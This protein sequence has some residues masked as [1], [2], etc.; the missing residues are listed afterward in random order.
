MREKNNCGRRVSLIGF[1][2]FEREDGDG[3][4]KVCVN[5]WL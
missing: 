3:G 1:S 5:G 2:S 4:L